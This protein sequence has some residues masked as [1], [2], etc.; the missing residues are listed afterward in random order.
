M[1]SALVTGLRHGSNHVP[2]G[3]IGDDGGCE[4]L[5][6]LASQMWPWGARAG[7]VVDLKYHG[8]VPTILHVH[9]VCQVS[10]L[11]WRLGCSRHLLEKAVEASGGRLAF[12]ADFDK[13]RATSKH[14]VWRVAL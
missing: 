12:S 9:V 6:Q 1:S 13:I 10:V 2:A 11:E 7:S 4:A 5:A 8:S 3:I 14:S